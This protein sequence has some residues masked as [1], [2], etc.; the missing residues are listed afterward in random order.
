MSSLTFSYNQEETNAILSK[1]SFSSDFL[2]VPPKETRGKDLERELRHQTNLELHCATLSEYLRVQRIP[3]GLRVPLRPTLF[4]DSIDFCQKFEQILNKCSF[5][6]MTLTVEHLQ[7][8]IN[9]SRDSI[10]NI[11]SQ[12][13]SSSTS[14]EL[15]TLKDKLKGIIDQHKRDTEQRKRIK[16]QRDTEDYNNNRVYH[17]RYNTTSRSNSSRF[18]QQSSNDPS[19][20][21]SE[22]DR[23]EYRSSYFL[24]QRR[25][26]PRRR[27]FVAA[28]EGRNLDTNRITRSQSRQ[29]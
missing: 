8:S 23:R 22:T 29:F 12:L 5:D 25:R 7:T 26:R 4:S 16:F 1:L 3:R 28:N 13:A 2:K 18:E 6:L 19:T 10:K 24:D 11:E 15:T 27:G 17:W 20:S 21:G 14:E 9:K